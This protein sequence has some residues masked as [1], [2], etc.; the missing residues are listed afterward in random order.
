[1]LSTKK[2]DVI[3]EH[4]DPLKHELLFYNFFKNYNLLADLA[5]KNIKVI[6]T[7]RENRT[8]GVSNK[9]K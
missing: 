4:S 7:I 5:A 1:M 6:G 8:L 3:A 2:V 9:I